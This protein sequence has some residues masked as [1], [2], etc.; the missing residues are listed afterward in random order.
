MGF[1]ERWKWKKAQVAISS[2]VGNQG[3]AMPK[4]TIKMQKRCMWCG[5]VW[6]S[7][8]AILCDQIEASI[9]HTLEFLNPALESGLLIPHKHPYSGINLTSASRNPRR[10]RVS[11]N[12]ADLLDGFH[13][14]TPTLIVVQCVI[15]RMRWCWGQR[16]RTWLGSIGFWLESAVA[17]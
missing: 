2:T 7:W 4:V 8:W 16:T 12:R 3:R 9:K 15:V 10:G 13:D 17:V 5:V 1:I 14:G 6:C 11:R